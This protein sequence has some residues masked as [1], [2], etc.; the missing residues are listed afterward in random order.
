MLR[1]ER[2]I[3]DLEIEETQQGYPVN[4]LLDGQQRLSTVCGALYW[5]G[6]DPKSRWNIAYDLRSQMFIHL[7]TLDDPP[8]H[9]IRLN[10]FPN[11][12]DYFQHVSSLDTLA[13]SDAAELKARAKDLFD[14]FKDYKI[15]AVTLHEMS[16]QSVA[17]IFERINS[18]GTALTIVDLMRAATWSGEFDL[19]DAI[20]GIQDALEAKNFG[21]IDR[22]S[23]LR[24]ISACA[25]GDFSESSIDG[26]RKHS[27]VELTSAAEGTRSGYER[28]VDFLSTE[29]RIPNDKQVPYANQIVV[30]AELFRLLPTPTATQFAEIS[31]W[32]WR[33]AVGG[34]FSGWNT[35]NMADDLETVRAFASG[36]TK[37]LPVR[38]PNPGTSVWL[39]QAFRINTAHAKILAML[40]AKNHPVDL[41]N[42]AAID[43]DRALYQGN[44]REFHHFFPRAWLESRRVTQRRIN[45]LANFVMLT[46]ASNKRISNRAPSDYLKE[47]QDTL[48]DNLQRALQ[49]NLISDAA[50]E[51]ALKDNYDAF[52]EARA[53]TIVERVNLLTGW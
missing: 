24:N 3:A 47:V 28:A 10:K 41:V 34:Y 50:F 2:N 17:P 12:S 21:G 42:G 6:P 22:K 43:V 26:L 38:V 37:T 13:A 52:L 19:I 16:L 45:V 9:Q 39:N 14:R 5:S 31:R 20:T 8:L 11:P 40:L 30:L 7:D 27:A 35:G 53:K 46:A 23:I 51:A 4:Y 1:S 15:A 48:G 49:Q 25:G 33:T 32:F 36:T 18:R 29:V 44:S